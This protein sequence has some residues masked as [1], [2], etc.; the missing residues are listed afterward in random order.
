MLFLLCVTQL[1]WP[2]LEKR[3]MKEVCTNYARNYKRH[4]KEGA[5]AW[6]SSSSDQCDVGTH[7]AED[8]ADTLRRVNFYRFLSGLT[9]HE[10]K[11]KASL[12][13]GAMQGA[14]VLSAIG[15]L[16]HYLKPD[17]QCY[18]QQAAQA[19]ANGNIA[20]GPGCAADSINAYMQDSGTPSL[21]HRRW[22]I[23]RGFSE[24]GIGWNARK[25]TTFGVLDVA[26]GAQINDEGDAP[27][28][29]YP[30]P[31][32][33]PWD[34]IWNYW[35]VSNS[36]WADAKSVTGSIT[37]DDGVVLSDRPTV[38]VSGYGEFA[39]SFDV[40]NWKT[41]V[42]PDREYTVV[43]RANDI[44]V[45]Y[46]VKTVN[47]TGFVPPDEEKTKNIVFIA[48]ASLSLVTMIIVFIIAGVRGLKAA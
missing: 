48:F 45:R 15:T 21:G 10:V 13:D 1:T 37:R 36:K 8:R 44:E 24:T 41:L 35:S 30:G 17:M 23:A 16:N 33:Q 18:T 7:N 19:A 20:A 47:C 25:P 38:L 26:S 3:G 6:T 40:T 4:M 46:V 32:A 22:I 2:E 11:E 31:G 29:A 5:K 43:M 27:F 14:A 9:K 12:T 28:V 39:C 34:L 42:E